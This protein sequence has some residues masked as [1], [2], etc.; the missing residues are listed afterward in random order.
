MRSYYAHH[1]TTAPSPSRFSD[2]PMAL[3]A[4]QFY[5]VPIFNFSTTAIVKRKTEFE[6][7]LE[8]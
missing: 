3:P 7:F 6:P 5:S 8:V 2:H 4:T 1:I